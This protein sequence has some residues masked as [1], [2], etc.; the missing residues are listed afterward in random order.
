LYCHNNF[1]ITEA[2]LLDLSGA[3]VKVP[4]KTPFTS[5]F[6]AT[7]RAG[8]PPSAV[9]D[10]LGEGGKTGTMRYARIRP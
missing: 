7:P 1:D 10:I 9:L 6:T 4:L 8:S 5:F 2:E 3:P